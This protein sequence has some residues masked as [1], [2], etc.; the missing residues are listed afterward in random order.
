MFFDD[1][2]MLF[3]YFDGVKAGGLRVLFGRNGGAGGD[4]YI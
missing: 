3:H 1:G 2:G 4:F